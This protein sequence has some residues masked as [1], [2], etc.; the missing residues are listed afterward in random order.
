MSTF[1]EM[2]RRIA[3]EIRRTDLSSQ[4]NLAIKSAINF[5]DPEEFWMD[6]TRAYLPTVA[7]REYYPLPSDYIA[8]RSLRVDTGSQ[9]LTL[10]PRSQEYLNA[11]NNSTDVE[12]IP[13]EFSVYQDQF[14]LYPVPDDSYTLYLDYEKSLADLS[15]TSDTNEF[16]TKGA[17]LIR[18]R[19]KW[20]ILKNILKRYDDATL[21]QQEEFQALEKMRE[22]QAR[23]HISS[24]IKG[25]I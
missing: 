4:I 14:R 21:A 5:Y 6:E 25:C 22:R 13:Y 24:G 16:M 7:S 8:F 9:K 2:N 23:Y 19:A 3:D 18:A 1:G 20:D 11:M 17:E 15:A 10:T 12:G